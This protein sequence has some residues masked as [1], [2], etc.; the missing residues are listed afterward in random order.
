MQDGFLTIA[1]LL[2]AAGPVAAGAG[3]VEYLRVPDGG[4]Q[5][6]AIA[7]GEGTLHLIYYRGERQNGNIFYVTRPRGQTEWSQPL[8]VNS[9]EGSADRN[10]A[11]SRAQ[12]AIDRNGNVHVVWFNMRPVKYWYTRK[13]SAGSGFERQR[14][15]VARHNDG[16]ETGAT[17]AVDGKGGV[18]VIWHAGDERQE[19]RRAVFGFSLSG[20]DLDSVQSASLRLNFV[21]T[22]LG[23]ATRL[24]EVNT[25]AIYA[26]PDEFT[27]DWNPE[28][29]RWDT[30]PDLKECR[31]VGTF[32]IPRSRQRG[33]FRFETPELIDYLKATSS[34]KVVFLALRQTPELQ[35]TG[36]VHAF[37]SST[38]PEASGPSLELSLTSQ[39]AVE[40]K[41]E[42][43]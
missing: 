28:T 6:Q 17:V 8:M 36:L 14:N 5:P 4:I 39:Q 30:V 32:D 33:S 38:H 42:N 22:G 40:D 2:A 1:F 23:F 15:L 9:Q 16:V 27:V 34:D 10:E 18:Y 29:L 37:A 21:P 35:P 20:I 41:A 24:A 26:L 11:I 7:D 13:L 25:F 3:E 43:H 19:D 31:P 12:M